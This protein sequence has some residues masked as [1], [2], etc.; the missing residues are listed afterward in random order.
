[1]KSKL[2][3][4]LLFLFTLITLSSIAQSGKIA[5]QLIDK[6]TGETIIGGVVRVDGTQFASV[7]DIEGRFS[8][9]GIPAG[10]YSVTV[11]FIGYKGQQ[12]LNVKVAENATTQL[13]FPMSED[14]KDL[15]EVEV[16]A[17]ISRS[18]VSGMLT[19]QK[20]NIAVSDVFSSEQMKKNPDK[21]SSDVLKRISGISIQDNKFVVV[22]GLNDRYNTAYLN[23]APLPSSEPDRKA[24]SFDMFPA[25]LLDNIVVIKSATPEMPGD[26]AGGVIQINTRNIPDSNF[27]SVSLSS[28]YN[29]LSTGKEFTTYTGGKTDFAGWDD[30]TRALPN[31]PSTEEFQKFT[32]AE[33]GEAAKLMKNDWALSTEKANAPMSF[34]YTFGRISKVAKNRL[35]TIVALT[36]NNSNKITTVERNKYEEQINEKPVLQKSYSDK[37]YSKQVLAG[38]LANFA[39]SVGSNSEITF[40]NMFN[41]NSEDKVLS[42]EG[43]RDLANNAGERILEKSNAMQYMQNRMYTG[44]IGG[45]HYLKTSEVKIKWTLG[46]SDIKRIVP[47]LRRMIYEKKDISPDALPSD[48]L[49]EYTA[50]INVTGTTPSSGGSIFS[51][52]NNE[53][54][55]SANYDISKPFK[56]GEIKNNLK[57]GGFHQM[58]NR[59][60]TSRTFGYTKYD[61]VGFSANAVKFDKQLLLLPQESIFAGEN[62]GLIGPKKGGFKLE[63]ATK[64]NDK[65]TASS[66][67]NA[68]YVMLDNQFL[69]NL[70]FIWGVRVESYNQKL[71]TNNDDGSLSVIDTSYLDVLPSANLIFSPSEKSNIRLCY[72]K[73]VARPEFREL[74]SFG[75]FDFLTNYSRKGNPKLERAQIDN[76]D[77]KY[78]YF[79]GNG[80]V[81]SATAFYKKFKNAIE[82]VNSSNEDRLLTF[83]NA[84]LATNYGLELEYRVNLAYLLGNENETLNGIAIFTNAAL[85]KSKVD[86][87]KIVGSNAKNRTLQGQSPYVLNCGLQY[88]APNKKFTFSTSLNRVGRRI[89]TAGNVYERDVYESARTSLDFQVTKTF[90]KHLELKLNLRDALA[91]NS[92]FYQDVDENKKYNSEADNTIQKSNAARVVSFTLGYSF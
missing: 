55:Y 77:L 59:E 13:D 49:P 16:V 90:F 92:V 70:R 50:A 54:I 33:K 31:L 35:G 1:M 4:L 20:N 42:R 72:S 62:M 15:K 39:Y 67:L 8:I 7:T 24:F 75:Y 63:E 65:Y 71:N 21:N 78:E 83:E 5:G 64:Q 14:L 28:G 80:Q 85:I 10:I 91:Q 68:G 45:E 11:N 73:T 57:I 25:N 27:N 46:Y 6:K 58:R 53:K 29:S 48:P 34:Q 56:I 37:E 17:K 22:R 79:P 26:F 89:E 43:M 82:Q 60:F 18:S 38:A 2:H 86:V 69:E 51:S 12:L 88:T 23:G 9:S 61:I 36:Y 52:V 3:L 84:P 40:K 76:F 19:L 81:I 74:A 44:Q 47:D 32:P 66:M 30:G 87:S 41:I